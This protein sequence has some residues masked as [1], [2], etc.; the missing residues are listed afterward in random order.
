MPE[1]MFGSKFVPPT[2]NNATYVPTKLALQEAHNTDDQVPVPKKEVALPDSKEVRKVTP[3]TDGLPA[4]FIY[5]L[6]LI[7]TKKAV[8]NLCDKYGSVKEVTLQADN[9]GQAL[10]MAFVSFNNAKDPDKAHDGLS[11]CKILENLLGVQIL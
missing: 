4:V 6:P 3:P 11:G 2:I 7:F 10:G 9:N 8:Y 5:N 1:Y